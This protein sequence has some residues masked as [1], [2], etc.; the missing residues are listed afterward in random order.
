MA[1]SDG[2]LA[3]AYNI[4]PDGFAAG[5]AALSRLRPETDSP[6]SVFPHAVV[7]M[8]TWVTNSSAQ[9]DRKL[10]E[11]AA[12]V[13]RDRDAQATFEDVIGAGEVLAQV[14]SGESPAR[15]RP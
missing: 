8:W 5:L 15:E 10:A 6:A 4:D 13:H 14:T 7:T 12:L 9:I 3:S 11:V 1:S 2:W